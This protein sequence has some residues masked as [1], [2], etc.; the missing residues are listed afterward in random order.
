MP[1]N[2]LLP[3]LLFFSMHLCISPGHC[4][5]LTV[6]AGL[7]PQD[8]NSYD[9]EDGHERSRFTVQGGFTIHAGLSELAID[10]FPV[11][12]SI[13][14][15]QYQ[16]EFFEAEGGLGGGYET[17]G[18]LKKQ[19]LGL[20][21]Y[22]FNVELFDVVDIS[23]GGMVS[24]LLSEEVSGKHHSWNII[25]GGSTTHFNS[26]SASVSEKLYFGLIGQLSHDFKLTDHLF[27]APQYSFYWS[28]SDEFKNFQGPRRLRHILAL[29]L[30]MKL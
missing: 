2:T 1:L 25:D 18:T 16:G 13:R 14:F 4:Q 7:M 17:R 6:G 21:A 23:L 19:T 30:K 20:V 11:D 10:S 8:L 28:W 22:P 24:I 9:K 3:V 26:D 12:F 5:K 29:Q 27:V 15:T